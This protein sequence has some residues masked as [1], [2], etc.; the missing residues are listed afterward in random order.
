MVKAIANAGGGGGGTPNNAINKIIS[1][2]APGKAA[3]GS[4]F[5]TPKPGKSLALTLY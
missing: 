1:R 3:P 2:V 5:K 4:A